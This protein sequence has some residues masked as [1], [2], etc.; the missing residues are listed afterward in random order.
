MSGSNLVLTLNIII[1]D[2]FPQLQTPDLWT[3]KTIIIIIHKLYAVCLDLDLEHILV[4]LRVREEGECRAM[5]PSSSQ[6]LL[7]ILTR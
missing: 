3:V 5:Q 1:N 4:W 7:H 2:N 6:N